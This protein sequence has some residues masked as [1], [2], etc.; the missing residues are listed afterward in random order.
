MNGDALKKVF[1]ASLWVVAMAYVISGI[2]SLLSNTAFSPEN[3]SASNPY[4]TVIVG[5]VIVYLV[6]EHGLR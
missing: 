1:G 2:N 3:L 5:S 6:F 4:V